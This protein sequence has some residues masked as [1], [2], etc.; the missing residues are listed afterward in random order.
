M[1]NKHNMKII[2]VKEACGQMEDWLPR[3]GGYNQLS[4]NLLTGELYVNHHI[5]LGKNNWTNFHDQS[6]INL[7]FF[8]S[9]LTM[10]E[11]CDLVYTKVQERSN[12]LRGLQIDEPEL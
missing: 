1:L 9:K 4:Y 7:G 12:E 11:V 5:S 6:I 2:G 10:Q 3:S 8:E